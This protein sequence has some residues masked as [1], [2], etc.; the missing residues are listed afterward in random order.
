MAATYAQIADHFRDQIERGELKQ[1]DRLPAIREI[2][3]TW[4]VAKATVDRAINQLRTDGLV[5]T[6]KGS[7]GTVVDV[8]SQAQVVTVAIGGLGPAVRVTSADVAIATERVAEDLD[9]PIGSA[10]VVVRLDLL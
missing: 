9:I 5:R 8:R 6:G 7:T 2:A 10:V 3:E 4:G 1:G